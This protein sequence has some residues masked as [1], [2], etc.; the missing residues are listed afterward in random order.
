[1]LLGMVSVRAGVW[2]G[3]ISPLSHSVTAY[4]AWCLGTALLRWPH[5]CDG[6]WGP[7]SVLSESSSDAECSV[8]PWRASLTLASFVVSLAL[9][10]PG[11]NTNSRSTHTPAPHF[12]TTVG[13]CSMDLS[14]RGW[15][16]TV[17]TCALGQPLL[18]RLLPHGL[19]PES[20]AHSPK[21]WVGWGPLA[22]CWVTITNNNHLFRA[23]FKAVLWAWIG[24]AH[25][26]VVG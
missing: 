21:S 9:R 25:T 15:N 20:A 17:S 19:G 12:V 8:K 10:T 14:T 23:R 6:C 2:M 11:A 26:C 13:H 3:A 7:S 4:P 5:R 18:T 16:V 22:W 24:L 1:M